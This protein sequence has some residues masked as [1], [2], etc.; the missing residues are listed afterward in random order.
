M[1]L[2]LHV[3]ISTGEREWREGEG[4]EKREGKGGK[5]N[6]KKGKEPKG[7][8]LLALEVLLISIISSGWSSCRNRNGL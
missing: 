1:P 7:G 8:T 6:E 2:M 4:R 5:K 3:L